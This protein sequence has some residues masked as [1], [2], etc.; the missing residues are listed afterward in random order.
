[1]EQEMQRVLSQTL[2]K[3]WVSLVCG[4]WTS[5]QTNAQSHKDGK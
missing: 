4:A 1:V 3:Y 5:I 2:L